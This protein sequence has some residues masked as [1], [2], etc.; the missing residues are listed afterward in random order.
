MWIATCFCKAIGKLVSLVKMSIRQN[1][2][3]S[4]PDELQHCR[5]YSLTPKPHAALAHAVL[6]LLLSYC[7]VGGFIPTF[8]LF[9][10]NSATFSLFSFNVVFYRGALVR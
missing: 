6:L 10:F 1:L 3:D 9:S 8:P 5:K 2:I 4:I 7:G